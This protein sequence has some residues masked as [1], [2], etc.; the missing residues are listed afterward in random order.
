MAES[1]PQFVQRRRSGWEA[2]ARLVE[3]LERAQLTLEDLQAL[4][5]HYRRAASDLAHA[6]TFFAGS[7]AFVY[8]NQL[9]A[10]AYAAIYKGRGPRRSALK[11]FFLEDFPRAVWAERRALWAALLVFAAGALVGLVAALADPHSLDALVP[12]ELREHIEQGA[13]WTDEA[14]SAT[15]PLVLGT[16]IV[17]NNAAV[18]LTAFALGL[19]AGLGTAALLFFNGLHLGSVLGLC[20]QA[21]LGLPLLGF[22]FAHGFVEISAILIAGQ[23]GFVLALAIVAP[24][25]LSRADALRQRGRTALTLV[26]GTLPLLAIVGMVEGFV[27]PGTLF[28]APVKLALGASLAALL[29]V[30]VLRFG[31]TTPEA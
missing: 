27:S 5:R 23:A 8:L 7:E 20:F 19:T 16:R 24:G 11:R 18:A 12:R 31:R 30:Y 21:K 13:L 3:G 14:L 22:I 15:T 25:Q 4:D 1:L 10:R 17:T 9:C 28:P 6:R 2:L 26:L 29:W